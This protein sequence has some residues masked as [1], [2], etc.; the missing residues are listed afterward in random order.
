M[1]CVTIGEN[2]VVQAAVDNGNCALYLVSNSDV[3]LNS[4][5]S[6]QWVADNGG[7]SLLQQFF[8]MGFS[9]PLICYLVAWAFEFI[10]QY[11]SK[12]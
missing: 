5:F 7:V 12:D 4:V 2:N 10:S 9:L 8:M 11:L 6:L 3:I 1:Q